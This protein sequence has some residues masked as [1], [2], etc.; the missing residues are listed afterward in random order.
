M[1]KLGMFGLAVT[2]AV[3]MSPSAFAQDPNVFIVHGIDGQDF[4]QPQDLPVDIAVNGTCSGFVNVPFGTV[5]STT[6]DPGPYEIAIY[7]LSD[8]NCGGTL[9][10]TATVDVAAFERS[11]IVAHVTEQGTPKITKFVDDI[12]D[13][14]KSNRSRLQVRHGAAAP[15]VN[16]VLYKKY[17]YTQHGYDGRPY[18]RRLVLREIEN[19]AQ[20]SGEVPADTYDV[21]V[22][23]RDSGKTIAVLK[24]VEV[25]AN[26]AIIA[27]A[28]G[29]P[30]NGT[31]DVVIPPEQFTEVNN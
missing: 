12:R 22:V 6:L 11:T 26:L 21:K 5:A 18:D 19:S 13:T 30:R 31:F 24:D 7:V 8:G 1:N 2:L 23:E 20:R 9:A 17:A 3:L 27:Y 16:V 10:I 15:R 14:K 4:G 29:S 25:P 28:V